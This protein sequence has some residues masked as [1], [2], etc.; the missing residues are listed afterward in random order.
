M[1][2]KL[3]Q[4]LRRF[5]LHTGGASA[6]EFAFI[7]P[8]LVLFYFGL[9][10]YTQALI[11][12]RRMINTASA[13]GDLVAQ[14]NGA[15]TSTSV[16]DILNMKNVLMSP[17]PVTSSQMKICV[18][19]IVNNGTQ[20]KVTWRRAQNDATCTTIGTAVTDVPS[21]LISSGESVIMS[22]VSYTYTSA[23]NQAIKSPITFTKTYYL[24][25]RRSS[26]ITC[27]TCT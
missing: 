12:Q 24:R 15:T 14:A 23:I 7:A 16:D 11:A 21:E 4:A 6:V 17:F 5:R 25:P 18:L 13:I 3:I 2:R 26:Q 8:V 27:P 1:M 10:E 9:A 20:N 19:S 22:K